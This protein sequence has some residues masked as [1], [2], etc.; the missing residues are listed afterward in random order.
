MQSDMFHASALEEHL[1]KRWVEEL[2]S[3]LCYK[4]EHIDPLD[5]SLAVYR[6]SGR[7]T[8]FIFI[9]DC[10]EYPDEIDERLARTRADGF[11]FA[12]FGSEPES[13]RVYQLGTYEGEYHQVRYI[14]TWMPAYR[15]T[16]M[17]PKNVC[18]LPFRA[19]EEIRRVFKLCHDVIYKELA[20]DPAAA[21]D[22][23]LLVVAAK[24]LDER[25][26]ETVYQFGLVE[27]EP[28]TVR[29]ERFFK[30]LA[31]AQQWLE[32]RAENSAGFNIPSVPGKLPYAIF[33]AFQDYSL[34]FTADSIAGTD[35]IGIAYESIVGSTFRGELGSYFTPRNI[36]D[37]VIRM[38]DVRRGSIFDPACGSGG[39]LLSARRFAA[40]QQ[41]ARHAEEAVAEEAVSVKCYGNDLN[42]RMVRAARVNFLL[43]SL[44]PNCILQGDG[45]QLDRMLNEF[46]FAE[47][48][49]GNGPWWSAIENG[50]FDAVVA[51]PPF[52][53][54]EQS[55]ENLSRVESASRPNGSLR[56]LNRTIPFLETIVA[57]LKLGGVAGI[58]LPTSILNAEEDSFVRFRALLLRHVELLAIIGLPERAF[59]HT[60]SGIHGALLFF[61]R[62]YEPRADYEIFVDWAKHLGYDR[63]GRYKRE[64]DFPR[65][66]NRYHKKPWPTGNTFKLSALLDHGRFDPAWLRVA[67]TLPRSDSHNAD[68]FVNLTEV[69][70]VRDERIS[71]RSIED[72][73][74]YRY[75]EVSDTDLETGAVRAIQE[76]SG[77]ELRKKGRIKKVVRNGDIL[78]PNHRDSLIAKG[79][80]TGRSVVLV[81]PELDGVLTTDRFITLRPS[82]DPLLARLLLNS[83]GVRRQIVAQCRGAASLDIRERTL[84]SV[85]VPRSIL[86]GPRAQALTER[87]LEVEK[88]R[89]K[90]SEQ[91]AGVQTA[92]EEQFGIGGEFRPE[93]FR[94]F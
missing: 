77:F 34:V 45:L 83:A 23:L 65:I 3:S 54:H 41:I 89:A 15:R 46:G 27:G 51:N 73:K 78:M 20:N 80:P 36:A 60:D 91:V 85:L 90:L 43:H 12:V 52:A 13:A 37:F 38:M 6:D 68:N 59:V 7:R 67:A 1:L 76:A 33:G 58:V 75:F 39:L 53:G 35:A 61:K 74:L 48:V 87:A 63:L 86:S 70:Q 40:S 5:Q 25:S 57:S 88:M 44:D 55:I 26:E 28:E 69:I 11:E 79:A 50:P 32:R 92:I 93:A 17:V 64:N 24:V 42:P 94:E 2:T 81:G 21:F 56:S 31:D 49:V 9:S 14:P 82:I 18:L 62:V 72:D 30:L 10:P 8:P 71:R 29:E 84:A 22:L 19:E 4:P 66:L 47:S 16:R